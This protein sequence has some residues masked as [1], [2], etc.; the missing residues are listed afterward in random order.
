MVKCLICHETL[1]TKFCFMTCNCTGVYHIECI[2][3]WLSINK[4]C[5]T[6]NKRF[7]SRDDSNIQLLKQA[8]FYDSIGR[9]GSFQ[10]QN[11]V[12]SYYRI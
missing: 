9:F 6:C 2:N 3:S 5:P 12:S 10:R 4:K 1:K 7:K 11:I 8:M